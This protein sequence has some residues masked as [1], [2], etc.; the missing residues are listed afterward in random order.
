MRD[1]YAGRFNS[2]LFDANALIIIENNN[3][4]FCDSITISSIDEKKKV[5]A[6]MH[7]IISRCDYIVKEDSAS[8]NCF[9]I[10]SDKAYQEF[11]IKYTNY[12]K[13]A[14]IKAIIPKIQERLIPQVCGDLNFIN[15]S[16]LQK[17]RKSQK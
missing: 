12:H 17:A 14:I 4:N 6:R 3:G 9:Y 2:K 11:W 16:T 8:V 15:I 13:V 10:Y 5:W 1:F 7:T